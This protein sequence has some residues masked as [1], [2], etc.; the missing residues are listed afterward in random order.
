MRIII[1]LFLLGHTTFLSAQSLN[2][3]GVDSIRNIRWEIAVKTTFINEEGLDSAFCDYEYSE[4]NIYKPD[5]YFVFTCDTVQSLSSYFFSNEINKKVQLLS[6]D[7]NYSENLKEYYS[8]KSDSLQIDTLHVQSQEVHFPSKDPDP[9]FL[10]LY[11]C[12]YE[13]GEK[14]GMEYFYYM[15]QDVIGYCVEDNWLIKEKGEWKHGRMHGKWIE[16]SKEG[17]ITSI[18]KYK[19]GKLVKEKS[20]ITSE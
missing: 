12:S 19:K 16:Y 4:F 18:S 3:S 13:G 14:H 9:G 17:V 1:A 8:K 7:F 10:T 5:A 2:T 6:D 11:R 20:F 15:I